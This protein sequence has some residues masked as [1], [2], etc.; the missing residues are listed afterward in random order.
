[1]SCRKIIKRKAD[2]ICTG[3]LDQKIKLRIKTKVANDDGNAEADLVITKLVDVWTMQQTTDGEEAF[4]SSNIVRIAT[5]RFYIRYRDDLDIT[6]DVL[7]EEGGKMI[8]FKIIDI[9]NLNG[10]NEFLLIR[11]SRRGDATLKNNFL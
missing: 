2:K 5:D 9:E 11:A 4:D 3:D 7:K 10:R 8:K 1:M 6:N